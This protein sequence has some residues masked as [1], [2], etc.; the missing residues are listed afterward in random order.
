MDEDFARALD[1][2]HFTV[3]TTT[4]MA[5]ME[6]PRAP[7]DSWGP[8][9]QLEANVPQETKKDSWLTWI[10]L[11]T[12]L[13]LLGYAAYLMWGPKDPKTKPNHI[14]LGPPTVYVPEKHD[15][16]IIVE[17]PVATQKEPDLL[18]A[19]QLDYLASLRPAIDLVQEPVKE[20]PQAA[21]VVPIAHTHKET[22]QIG[23][24]V[25]DLSGISVRGPYPFVED[26]DEDTYDRPMTEAEIDA[27]V[28][29][30][31]AQAEQFGVK[32]VEDS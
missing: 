7:V 14:D 3:D 6:A 26:L 8:P 22:V 18:D 30:R 1:S 17:R 29:A 31:E 15:E 4:K 5:P 24:P 32:P 16:A 20:K 19:S 27:M 12:G 9:R 28:K 23:R 10:I 11:L 2:L 13:G 21:S 25:S